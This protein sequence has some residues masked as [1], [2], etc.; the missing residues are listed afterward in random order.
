MLHKSPLLAPMCIELHA[1]WSA[2]ALWTSILYCCIKII[3]I[4]LERPVCST[5]AS[6]ESRGYKPMQSNNSLTVQ[7]YCIKLNSEKKN[8]F[9]FIEETQ[10]LCPI[11]EHTCFLASIRFNL[12]FSC[13]WR[14]ASFLLFFFLLWKPVTKSLPCYVCQRF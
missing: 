12:T 11:K 5:F 3:G 10:S 13:N 9:I 4:N 2:F 8:Q 1:I 14:C 6:N 7:L